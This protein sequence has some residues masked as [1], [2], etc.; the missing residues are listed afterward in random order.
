MANGD[1]RTKAAWDAATWVVL[2]CDTNGASERDI[3]RPRKSS[4]DPAYVDASKNMPGHR[5]SVPYMVGLPKVA[6]LDEVEEALLSSLNEMFLNT[7]TPQ[8]ALA[9]AETKVNAI[10]AS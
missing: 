10:L 3:S 4:T 2:N 8:Q 6:K 9:E 5:D 7:K 1:Q